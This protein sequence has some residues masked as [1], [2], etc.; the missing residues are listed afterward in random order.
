MAWDKKVCALE[1]IQNCLFKS[2]TL[3][4]FT[5][6]AFGIDNRIYLQV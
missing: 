5:L 1:Y 3:A 2:L 4:A 6:P